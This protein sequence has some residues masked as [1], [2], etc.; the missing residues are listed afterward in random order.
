MNFVNIV[1]LIQEP[2]G[3]SVLYNANITICFWSPGFVHYLDN[4]KCNLVQGIPP[5]TNNNTEKRN[6]YVMEDC[7]VL[8]TQYNLPNETAIVKEETLKILPTLT[9]GKIKKYIHS[10]IHSHIQKYNRML[11]QVKVKVSMHN[12]TTI[13][14]RTYGKGSW[15]WDPF[16][17]R[18]FWHSGWYECGWQVS[19]ESC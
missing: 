8:G 2:Y 19:S 16:T 3:N 12:H 15:K 7:G 14:P 11:I 1:W 9:K 6:Y 4:T 17:K 13:H 10:S 5:C 18:R